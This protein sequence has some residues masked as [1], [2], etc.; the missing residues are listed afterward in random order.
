MGSYSITGTNIILFFLPIVA[1]LKI[2]KSSNR[3]FLSVYYFEEAFMDTIFNS[4]RS[5]NNAQMI[6][7]F[8]KKTFEVRDIS[9]E[10]DCLCYLNTVPTDSNKEQISITHEI[11]NST[12]GPKCRRTKF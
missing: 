7:G 11:R 5:K 12:S 1:I 9:E 8:V 10:T 6:L 2:N 3:V 4:L